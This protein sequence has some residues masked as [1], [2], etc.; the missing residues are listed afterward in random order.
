MIESL[1]KPCRK[2]TLADPQFAG[3]RGWTVRTSHNIFGGQGWKWN[4]PGSAW[5][6]QHLWEHYAF[7]R[8]KEYLRRR[9]YPVLKEVCQFWEDTLKRL[10]DGTLVVPKGWSPEH[11][12]VE[13]GVSYDQE[14]VW[15]LFTNTIEASEALG[16]DEGFRRKLAAMRAKLLVPRIGRWGQLQE[17][18]VDRD[19]PN[20]HHRHCS[21]LFGL[22]PGRQ[23]SP[24]T[25]PKLAQAARVS[26]TARGD[27]GTGWSKA[28]KISF[29][30]RLLDGDHAYKMLSEQLKHNTLDNLW[31]T[32]PPFQIDG[33]FGATAG[34]CEMLLQSQ[35][36]QVHLLPA[37]PSAWPNGSVHGLRARGAFEVDIAWKD[38]RLLTAT[39][40]STGGRTCK[41]R[42]G[43]RV[44]EVKLQPGQS[45]RL[46]AALRAI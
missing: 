28:W 9:A 6:C 1:R 17:W 21:H 7:G 12:P 41:V 43:D 31:D 18:A 34:V 33:N 4:K 24:V 3:A 2:A 20:D 11:G 46:D 45:A 40:R 42:Y 44:V 14:I 19:D 38:G 23:I 39:I 26:L 8:D 27:G 22:H 30:A 13:D 32:H 35:A 36:G 16:I 5:Y 25:T 29:W 37:L 10:P 15:D